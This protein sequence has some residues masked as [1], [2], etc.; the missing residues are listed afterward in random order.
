MQSMEKSTIKE[1]IFDGKMITCYF[2]NYIIHFIHLFF[3]GFILEGKQTITI[4]ENIGDVTEQILT[5][6]QLY[7]HENILRIRY[8]IK[9]RNYEFL[10]PS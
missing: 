4:T 5:A 6:L 2:N 8:N 10:F 9:V 7:Q 1:D 3:L